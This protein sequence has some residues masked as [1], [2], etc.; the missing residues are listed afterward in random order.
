MNISVRHA[1]AADLPEI[2]EIVNHA[3]ANTTA[4]YDEAPRSEKAHREWFDEKLEAGFP[5]IVAELDGH[6]AGFGAYGTFKPKTG[7]RFTVEHSVYVREDLTGKGIGKLLLSKLIDLA[8]AQN[9][10]A[11]IGVIDAANTGSIAFHKQFGFIEIGTLKE[12]GFKF[13][14]W[15][16]VAFLQLRID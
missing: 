14:R 2:L 8:K 15:L 13:G 3:I 7:Y 5:I 9:I 10:H 1:T 11:M 16:D 12:V 6:V 4:I